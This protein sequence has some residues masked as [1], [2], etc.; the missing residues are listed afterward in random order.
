MSKEYLTKL[1]IEEK[2]RLPKKKLGLNYYALRFQIEQ[3]EEEKKRIFY[4]RKSL[5]N[6]S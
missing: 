3:E 4:A 6:N 2:L 5:N 1:E